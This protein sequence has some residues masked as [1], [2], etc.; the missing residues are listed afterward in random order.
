M[1]AHR[2]ED[3]F[4]VTELMVVL[5]LLSIVTLLMFTFLAGTSQH[6]VRTDANS[7]AEDDA[8]LLLRSLSEDVRSLSEISSTYP[9]SGSC[10]TGGTFASPYTGYK[11]CISFT[12][13][14]PNSTVPD[15]PRTEVVYGIVGAELRSDRRELQLSGGSCVVG[16]TTTKKVVLDKVNNGT[17]PLFQYLSSDNQDL[18]AAGLDPAN[19]TSVKI[20]VKK[21]YSNTSGVTLSFSQIVALRNHR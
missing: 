12:I 18:I 16:T 9:S 1:M 13:L 10:P 4:T 21:R 5:G 15:C 3:G 20:S 6:V 2:K 19:A 11:N 8:Q 14:R 7:R 17:T